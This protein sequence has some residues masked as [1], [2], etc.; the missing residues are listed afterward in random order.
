MD[1]FKVVSLVPMEQLSPLLK[2][3]ETRRISYNVELSNVKQPAIRQMNGGQTNKALV[4]EL[5]AKKPMSVKEIGD[6][7]VAAGR[8]RQGCHGPIH[9]MKNDKT[10]SAKNGVYSVNKGTAK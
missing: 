5:L 1:I 9:Q 6:A 8:K 3:M 7:F 4:L 2:W 10:I